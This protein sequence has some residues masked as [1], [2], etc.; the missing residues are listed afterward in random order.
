[1][2]F[3]ENRPFFDPYAFGG[4]INFPPNMQPAPNTGGNPFIFPE[5]SPKQIYE[6]QYYYY[7][8]LNEYMDYQLK[9]RQFE[10]NFNASNQKQN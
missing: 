9:V 5:L 1:M 10:K 8:Y 4:G 3:L 2:I 7:R 6:S